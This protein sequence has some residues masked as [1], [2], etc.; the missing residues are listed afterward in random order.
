M[1]PGEIRL[2]N[3]AVLGTIALS[4]TLEHAGALDRQLE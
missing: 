3:I 4:H 1:L 2:A